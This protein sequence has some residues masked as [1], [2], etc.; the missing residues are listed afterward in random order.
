MDEML[1]DHTPEERRNVEL[2]RESMGI[3]C[4]PKRAS[5]ENMAHLC[6]PDNVFT[7]P[8]TCPGV[9][10]LEQYGE[11][12]G[13]MKEVADLHPV[14]FDVFYAHG[15]RLCLRYKA[16]GTHCGGPHGDIPPGGRKAMW[17]AA[18][19]FRVEGNKLAVFIKDW[20]RLSMWRQLGWPIEERLTGPKG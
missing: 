3:A 4:D 9:R 7:A 6:A 17:R 19:L 20:N 1:P 14:S 2:V 16:E 12:H 11:E 18:A 13:E 10:T 8:T 15:D 5:A